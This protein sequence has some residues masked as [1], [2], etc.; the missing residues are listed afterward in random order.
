M[1]RGKQS[2]SAQA[3]ELLLLWARKAAP[4]YGPSG[5]MDLDRLTFP[6][7]DGPSFY[8]QFAH[9]ALLLLSEGIVP[10]A[11]PK[12]AGRFRELALKNIR[13][14]LNITDADFMT[15][16]YSR[17]RDWGKTLCEWQYNF[18]FRSAAIIQERRLS[19]PAFRAELDRA[20]LG[21]TEKLR[22][23]IRG[24]AMP[25]FP[26]NHFTWTAL[27]LYEVGR[28]YDRRDLAADGERAFAENVLPF[29][30]GHGGWPEGGGIVVTYA[31]VTTHAV[32]DYA[33]LSGRAAARAAVEK[34][35]PFFKCFTFADGTHAV[36]ADCRMRYS[37]VPSVFL[38]HGFLHLTGGPE[39]CL[40]RIQGKRRH[41][42]NHELSDNGAQGLAFY[43]DFVERLFRSAGAE[44]W[45]ECPA[46]RLGALPVA[47]L[48]NADWSALLSCQRNAE[49]PS[50]FCYDSQN[51]IE[52][53]RRK[54]GC[55]LGGGNGKY[56]PRFSTFRKTTGSRGYIPTDA[57]LTVRAPDNA[58]CEYAFDED[59]LQAELTLSG[60]EL[61]LNFRIL[62]RQDP[63]DLYEAAIFLVVR[64]GEV[65][66][67]PGQVPSVHV[68]ATRSIQHSFAA[69]ECEFVWRGLTFTVPEGAV[70]D[71][72][73]IPH[74]PYKQDSLPGPEEYVARLGITLSAEESRIVIHP[75]GRGRNPRFIRYGMG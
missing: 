70:L 3:A 65:I 58:V 34:A 54:A 4:H 14:V 68:D 1:A 45:D 40:N 51:F 33:E 36:V 61:H 42:E 18:L 29:Q 47:R 41:L 50:R 74:N 12:E 38:P 35:F 20:V 6:D 57:T 63:D 52:A 66:L 67:F 71:Y 21:G 9:Y 5:S 49:T 48:D 17:G 10:G 44:A 56:A 30:E 69:D 16:H 27:L 39:F 26:G 28:H 2:L 73:I 11:K 22:G 8:N 7:A 75:A 53:W 37:P 72:P 46:P 19:T 15:P 59:R 32:S 13:Y 64:L 62:R 23:T 31:L 55:V 60:R 24:A 25:A 43:A